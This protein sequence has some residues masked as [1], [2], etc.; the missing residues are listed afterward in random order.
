MSWLKTEAKSQNNPELDNL[1]LVLKEFPQDW[2]YEHIRMKIGN[3]H[4]TLLD[5]V[6]LH[7]SQHIYPSQ[8]FPGREI[9]NLIL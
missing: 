6:G 9:K 1:M 4:I 2:S 5:K 7:Y 8:F 3:E